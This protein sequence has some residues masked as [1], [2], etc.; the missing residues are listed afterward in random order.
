MGLLLNSNYLIITFAVLEFIGAYYLLVGEKKT[1]EIRKLILEDDKERNVVYV[2][3]SSG[4]YE[5]PYKD[6]P[7]RNQL[8]PNY[9]ELDRILTVNFRKLKR[10][11][12]PAR[13]KPN[14]KEIKRSITVTMG[15][16]SRA[17]EYI[18]VIDET[19]NDFIN[20]L[21]TFNVIEQLTDSRIFGS[22][23]TD[24]QKLQKDHDYIKES[25]VTY[26]AYIFLF[27]G[28]LF[29][30]TYSLKVLICGG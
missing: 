24:N 28:F 21:L 29:Q 17:D 13:H 9:L 1:R 3:N 14:Q 15:W 10:V 8:K 12:K 5:N 20:L 19:F 27:I 4:V 23:K 26:G 11:F 25:A 2:R 7:K 18:Y 16:Q 6:E 30:L 22:H